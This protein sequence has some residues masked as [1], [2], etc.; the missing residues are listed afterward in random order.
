MYK[1]LLI[2]SLSVALSYAESGYCEYGVHQHGVAEFSIA[3]S[4]QEIAL[5]LHTPAQNVLGFEHSPK[6]DKEKQYVAER[7]AALK[8][9]EQLFSF[10]AKAG[11]ALRS[12]DS[13]SP[14]E[15]Q[16][17]HTEI[18]VSYHYHCQQPQYLKGID[19]QGLFKQFPGFEI[20]NAQWITDKQQSAKSL[21]KNDTYIDFSPR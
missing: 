6:T 13:E 21:N 9:A 14:F 7:L 2:I 16:P 11:C 12:V 5:D 8:N 4:K 17:T 3:W 15:V 19:T 18:E 1:N 10:D 20:L